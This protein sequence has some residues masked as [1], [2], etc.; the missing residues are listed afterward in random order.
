MTGRPL[1]HRGHR[2]TVGAAFLGLLALGPPAAAE[3]VELSDL[4]GVVVEADIHREQEVRRNGRTFSNRVHQRWKLSIDGKTIEFTNQA[5]N[6]GP[7]GT[8]KTRPNS[9]TFTLDESREVGSRGGG[10]ALWTFADGVLTFVRTFR[11]GAYRV[12]F[13][14]A[15]GSDG[16][17]CAVDAAY[18]REDGRPIRLRSPFGGG[19]VTIVDARQTSSSCRVSKED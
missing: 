18:A 10:E 19:E 14:F 8:R 17:T 6:R 13:A 9:A 3:G 12:K 11:S 7:R 4:D 16:L 15:R 1:V 5:T 2:A